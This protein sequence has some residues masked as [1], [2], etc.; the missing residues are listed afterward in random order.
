VEDVLEFGTLG[1]AK[2][3]RRENELGSLE[4]GKLADIAI[5]PAENLA[6][7]GA[8]NPV[9]G[10]VL[11]RPRDVDALVIQGKIRVKDGKI[12]DWDPVQVAEQHRAIARKI[13]E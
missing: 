3:L 4:P 2:I 10:L 6:S 11:C 5:F 13:W 12:L 7:L 1:G 8:E 9:L